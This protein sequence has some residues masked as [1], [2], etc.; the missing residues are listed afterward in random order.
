MTDTMNKKIAIRI[1]DNLH[2]KGGPA[3]KALRDKC[4]G[5]KKSRLEVILQWG[6][7][8]KWQA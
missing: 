2:R 4:E 6:D 3:E 7:P 5:E 8:R 1:S